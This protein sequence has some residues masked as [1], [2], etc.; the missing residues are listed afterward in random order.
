MATLI[1]PYR[2]TVDSSWNGYVGSLSP[3]AWWPLD[4]NDNPPENDVIDDASGNGRTGTFNGS[5]TFPDRRTTALIAGS[6]FSVTTGAGSNLRGTHMAMCN[7]SSWT[8]GCW[9]QGTGT[10]AAD[11]V[12]RQSAFEGLSVILNYNSGNSSGAISLYYDTG[13]GDANSLGVSSTGWN[14]GNPHLLFVEY[15]N[16][17]DRLAIWLD[18]TKIGD[19]ARA[20][21]KPTLTSNTYDLALRSGSSI[22]NVVVDEYLFFQRVLNSTEHTTL[23][24]Y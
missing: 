11:F 2:F 17:A 8:F 12:R 4:D 14:D 15:D 7:S 3:Y 24:S 1:N 21:T 6:T 23:A 20:G 10:G 19:R 5:T 16:G 22:A 13:G 9:I 18:G